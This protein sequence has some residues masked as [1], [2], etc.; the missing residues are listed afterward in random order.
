[1][2]QALDP[3]PGLTGYLDRLWQPVSAITLT[4]KQK[5]G[6]VIVAAVACLMIIRLKFWARGLSCREASRLPIGDEKFDR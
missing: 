1:L 5:P 6:L 2:A 4:R 3:P